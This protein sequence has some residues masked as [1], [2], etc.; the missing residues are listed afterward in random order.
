MWAQS[1]ERVKKEREKKKERER[2]K[3]LKEHNRNS[4]RRVSRPAMTA[5]KVAAGRVMSLIKTRGVGVPL[6]GNAGTVCNEWIFYS[7]PVR[8]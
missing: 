8:R 5:P 4:T 7:P 6:K 1:I 3:G 2:G